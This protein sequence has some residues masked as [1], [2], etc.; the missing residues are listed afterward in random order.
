MLA[1]GATMP[2]WVTF[3]PTILPV[4]FCVALPL[5]ICAAILLGAIIFLVGIGSLLLLLF[6]GIIIGLLLLAPFMLVMR[7]KERSSEES[8]EITFSED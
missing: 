5:F 4:T 2:L 6:A 1:T 7:L 3:L 8:E